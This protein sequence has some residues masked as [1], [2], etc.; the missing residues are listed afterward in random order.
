M[1]PA[2]IVSVVHLFP[3]LQSKLMDVLT[4]LSEDDWNKPTVCPDWSVRDIA[5]HLLDGDIRKLSSG[6]DGFQSPPPS[7]SIETFEDLVAYLNSLNA[8]WVKVARRMSPRLLVDFIGL[9]GPEVA[10]LMAS[11]DPQGP[12]RIPVRWAGEHISQNWFD[13][14]REYTERWHHQQQIRDAVR[15]EPITSRELLN[16]VLDVF[17]R[18]LPHTY[19]QVE[20]KRGQSVTM[21]ISGE[22]GGV[23]SLVREE[24]SWKL[25]HGEPDSADAVVSL[26][27]ETAWRLF[28]KAYKRGEAAEL[29]ELKGDLRLAR[30]FLSAVAVMA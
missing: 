28:T 3:E 1:T 8:E 19:R 5:A 14:G 4:N 7:V 2:G 13:I 24:E 30:P 22:A 6:H 10:E 9:T 25:F 21:R 18:A 26:R 12:S 29:V 11:L 27:A 20:A 15:A 23:W 16:P 17:L